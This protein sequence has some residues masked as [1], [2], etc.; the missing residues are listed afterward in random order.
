[1]KTT[2]IM[3]MALIALNKYEELDKKKV[4]TV[5]EKQKI[6]VELMEHICI[7]KQIMCNI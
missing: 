5:R 6:T 1:M 7:K 3:T 2:I 4:V